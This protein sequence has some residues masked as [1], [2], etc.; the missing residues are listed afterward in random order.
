MYSPDGS[1]M[2][3]GYSPAGRCT[4]D[5]PSAA[6]NDA[7]HCP[8]GRVWNAA[9]AATSASYPAFARP[10]LRS[11]PMNRGATPIS[12]RSIASQPNVP[13][14]PHDGSADQKPVPSSPEYQNP[15]Q[16]SPSACTD[17]LSFLAGTNAGSQSGRAAAV[18]PTAP[19]ITSA[20]TTIRLVALVA[21]IALIA[22]IALFD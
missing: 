7:S 18:P 22:C 2:S 16:N 10:S 20:H 15:P 1:G 14:T 3:L 21:F 17:A 9:R 4:Y 8:P 6:A 5:Q 19:R 13:D 11:R 12:I